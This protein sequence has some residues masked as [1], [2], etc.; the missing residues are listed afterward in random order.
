MTI[1]IIISV[2]FIFLLTAFYAG[3][4]GAP[5]VPTR[6]EDIKRFLKLANIKPGQKMYDLGCGDGR[7]LC[8]AAKIGAQAYGFEISLPLFIAA[9]I[10][11]FFQKD[12]HRIRILYRDFWN[13]DLSDADIVYFFLVPK[14]YPKLKKKFEKELK[15]G[16]IVIAYVW[17]IK[18]WI[19]AKID[20]KNH[21]SN[22][23]LYKV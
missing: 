16:T 23:Y 22:L 14:V 18:G 20:T 17:P 12:K 2:I 7:L 21:C 10:Q 5:W 9:H 3:W 4:R 13:M 15:S 8:A 19:P 6:K 1:I 11:R